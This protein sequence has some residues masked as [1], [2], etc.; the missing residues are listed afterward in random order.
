MG[1]IVKDTIWLTAILCLLMWAVLFVFRQKQNKAFTYAAML[2]ACLFINCLEGYFD[3]HRFFW[4]SMV[5]NLLLP[6]TSTLIPIATIHYLFYLASPNKT[7]PRWSRLFYIF[8]VAFFIYSF[9]VFYISIPFAMLQEKFYLLPRLS[10]TVPELWP[11]NLLLILRL[12][13]TL[14]GIL[15]IMVSSIFFI[16]RIIKM[17][18]RQYPDVRERYVNSFLAL[19]STG[20][21][22]SVV[23]IA[24]YATGRYYYYALMVS[25]TGIIISGYIM[26]KKLVVRSR[27]MKLQSTEV[28]AA[29]SL[30]DRLTVYFEESKPWLAPNLKIEDVS[31]ALG[32]NRT[33]LSTL[34]K[35][36][37]QTNFNHFV[38]S[39]RI[40]E[41]KR[42]LQYKEEQAKMQE[43]AT[44][45]GFNSY[46][47]FFNAFRK[48]MGM[49][50]K[51][52][53]R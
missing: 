11:I 33:Y 19:L 30:L 24:Y 2:F 38:N 10:H 29:A 21:V 14:M 8:P 12:I 39:Y 4:G 48:E 6:V 32:T 17:V 18:E 23:L 28:I 52:F 53:F 27:T 37:Y 46:T 7:A 42:L 26:Y 40:A 20:V 16:P 13:Y 51:E 49:S 25:L 31:A 15:V 44:K 47:T 3:M 43:I 34:L 36:E 1:E 41:A 9:Y 45:T 5:T 35:D 22:I 50:P